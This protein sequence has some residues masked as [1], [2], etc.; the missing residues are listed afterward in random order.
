MKI[1]D[2]RNYKFFCLAFHFTNLIIYIISYSYFMIGAITIFDILFLYSL[3]FFGLS[4]IFFLA[5]FFLR[6]FLSF[7]R[8]ELYIVL[9]FS[10]ALLLGDF[11]LNTMS[12]K[13]FEEIVRPLRK[14]QETFFTSGRSLVRDKRNEAIIKKICQINNSKSQMFIDYYKVDCKKLEIN[15]EK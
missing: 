2:L 3:T 5:G 13:M 8:K 14:T 10:T 9:I 11:Y 6:R 4:F 12:K 7:S 15:N 1:N